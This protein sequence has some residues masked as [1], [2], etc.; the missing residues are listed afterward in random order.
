[1]EETFK[2]IDDAIKGS[3][4]M[5]VLT[6]IRKKQFSWKIFEGNAS[7]LMEAFEKHNNLGTMMAIIN[8]NEAAFLAHHELNRRFHNF[9]AGCKTLVDHSRAFVDQHYHGTDVA[10][11]YG[12]YIQEHFKGN[13]LVGFVHDL[14]NYALHREI[15]VHVLRMRIGRKFEAGISMKIAVLRPWE[16]WTA[17][18]KAFIRDLPDESDPRPIIAE[19]IDKVTTCHQWLDDV[20]R[21]H[22]HEEI[23]EL[24]ELQQKMSK[25]FSS[26]DRPEN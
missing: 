7:D 25:F 22:H 24:Q 23:A 4:G 10:E 2:S 13:P 1:M 15:P 12:R 21:T 9:L 18:A 8:D 6:R 16:G 5:V 3:R 11:R 14:R 19:Y 17:P 26:A 20:L